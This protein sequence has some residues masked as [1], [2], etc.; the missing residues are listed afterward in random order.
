MY[1]EQSAV[2]RGRK[3]RGDEFYRY[4]G[5][6][7][8]ARENETSAEYLEQQIITELAESIDCEMGTHGTPIQ[9]TV[10]EGAVLSQNG[11]NLLQSLEEWK[12]QWFGVAAR[13]DTYSWFAGVAAAEADEMH[14]VVLFNQSGSIGDSLVV[15]SPFPEEAYEYVATRAQVAERGF[16]PDIKRAFIR[17]YEKTEHGIA[18]HIQSVDSSSLTIWNQVLGSQGF[19]PAVSSQ[20]LLERRTVYGNITAVVILDELVRAYDSILEL[21][22]GEHH[23]FGRSSLLSA[24]SNAFVKQYPEII[25]DTIQELR[26]IPA[27]I[28]SAKGDKLANEALYKSKALLDELF[29]AYI[30]TGVHQAVQHGH[31]SDAR[32]GAGM[33][34]RSEGK[35]FYGCSGESVFE[36]ASGD[37]NQLGSLSSFSVKIESH[38]KT[39]NGLEI[40]ECV[41]CPLCGSTVDAIYDPKSKSY[42]CVKKRCKGYNESMV[43]RAQNRHAAKEKDFG[44]LLAEFIFG[45]EKKTKQSDGRK[46]KR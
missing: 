45:E 30:T 29:N 23:S 42:S 13:N 6:L 14:D 19:N 12:D 26:A 41:T 40:H 28:S 10:K 11:D 34:A 9:L 16:R 38:R 21:Q 35:A 5:L 31:V 2:E 36:L 27:S 39:N 17:V 44:E 43:Q 32:S 46:Q 25:A 7:A 4:L 20:D 33:I 1:T 24:E 37:T 22:K 3:P 18:E 8:L 15:I